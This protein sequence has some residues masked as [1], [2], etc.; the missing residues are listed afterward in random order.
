[1]SVFVH[2]VFGNDTVLNFESPFVK[3]FDTF[4]KKSKNIKNKMIFL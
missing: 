2:L 4:V 1:V 3:N